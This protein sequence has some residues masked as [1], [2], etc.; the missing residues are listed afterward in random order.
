MSWP[1]RTAAMALEAAPSSG[2]GTAAFGILTAFGVPGC[3]ADRPATFDVRL[4][5]KGELRWSPT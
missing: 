1:V 3:G 2:S 5:E 4:N